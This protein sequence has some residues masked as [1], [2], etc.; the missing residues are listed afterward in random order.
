MKRLSIIFVVVIVCSCE[1]LNLEVSTQ[2]DTPSLE[3]MEDGLL[4]YIQEFMALYNSIEEKDTFLYFTDPHLLG[5]DD[6]FTS[7]NQRYLI[8][9]FNSVRFL[10]NKLPFSFCLCGG[11]WLNSGDSQ[12]TAILKLNYVDAQ[13]KEWF[14]PYYKMMGNH[15]YNY[16][17]FVSKDNSQRGD[18]GF[19]YINNVYFSQFGKSYYSFKGQN[20]VFYILDSGIDWEP[21]INDYRSE[22]LFWLA[23]QLKTNTAEHIVIGIHMF[24]NEKVADNKP[25]PFSVELVSLCNAFNSRSTYVYHESSFD[26]RDSEGVVHFFL[27]GHNHIDYNTLYNGIPIVGSSRFIKN[28]IPTFDLCV[29]DYDNNR[30]ELVRVGYGK[31]R[32][33]DFYEQ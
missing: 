8:D 21:Q 9:S 20:T 1:R 13:M 26:F 28:D 22:Q 24:Y 12:S 3:S 6:V 30:L 29:I 16:Q 11:D 7:S 23:N 15:D 17:G 33:V 5:Y 10:Y 32:C 31:S 18:L 2:E 4:P 27:S 14:Q 19:E 25:M